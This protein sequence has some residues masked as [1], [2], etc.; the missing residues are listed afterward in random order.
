MRSE[1]KKLSYALAK[2]TLGAE[3]SAEKGQEVI[4]EKINELCGGEFNYYSFMDN[5][6]KVFQVL[7]ETLEVATSYIEDT[8]MDVLVEYKDVNEGDSLTFIVE[9]PALFSVAQTAVGTNDIARQRLSGKRIPTVEFNLSVKI[10]EELKMFMAGRVDFAKMIT[11]V[12]KSFNVHV[13]NLIAQAMFSSYNAL[14]APYLATGAFERAKLL[15][16]CAEIEMNGQAPVIMGTKKA[17]SHLIADL[18]DAPETVKEQVWNAGF[19]GNYFGSP[20]VV[21][22]QGRYAAGEKICDD[23]TLIVIPQGEKPVKFAWAG[24]AL[25]AESMDGTDNTLQQVEYLMSRPALMA[26][27]VYN[28]FAMYRITD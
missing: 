6:Y 27:I 22:P 16:L 3:Y 4:R 9:D 12:A 19:I 14:Q 28:N 18:T 7:A 13:A 2:G 1:I 17:V 20:V 11:K 25:V 24:Q 10:Y 23:S 26:V 8:A 15:D 5:K 21:L